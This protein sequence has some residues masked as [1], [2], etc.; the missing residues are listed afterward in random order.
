MS[1]HTRVW[2]RSGSG[3]RQG[4]AGRLALRRFWPDG[5]EALW[6]EKLALRAAFRGNAATAWGTVQEDVALQRC[7]R[8]AERCP[9]RAGCAA[10]CVANSL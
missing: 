8:R 4:R 7:A 1:Y 6:E 2:D 9:Q 10:C 3:M 5:R